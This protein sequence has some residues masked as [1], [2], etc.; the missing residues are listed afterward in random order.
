MVGSTAAKDP[1]RLAELDDIGLVRLL[2]PE[3]LERK[4]N[5]IFG[6]NWGRLNEQFKILYGGIDTKEVTERLPDPSGAMGA[7]QR[8]MANE[9]ACKNVPLDFSLD[10]EKRR[11]FPGIEID[12]EPRQ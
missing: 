3:Q 10:P 4:L 9:V 8:M 2:S 1:A 6:K 5:A 12:V 11:L 7:I